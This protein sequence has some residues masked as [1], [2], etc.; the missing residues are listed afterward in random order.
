MP[1]QVDWDDPER[2]TI[3]VS[4]IEPWDWEEFYAAVERVRRMESAVDR[5]PD[6]IVDFTASPS[7]PEGALRHFR[8]V[9]REEL[10][11]EFFTVVVGA[12]IYVRAVGDA[13]ARI[14]SGGG[15]NVHF[16]NTLEEARDLLRHLRSGPN[17][18]TPPRR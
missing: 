2:A 12:S 7:L 11:R 18:D 14:V 8:Q 15:R 9:R 1:V 3:R 4:F 17:R 6:R 10:R 16:T 13:V 5:Q